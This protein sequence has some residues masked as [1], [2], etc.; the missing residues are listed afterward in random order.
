[1][2]RP[3][4]LVCLGILLAASI[5][6]ALSGDIYTL[7]ALRLVQGLGGCATMVIVYAIAGFVLLTL[8]L[9]HRGQV[10]AAASTA[11]VA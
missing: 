8:C 6:C 7:L 9:P 5:G 11:T 1:M 4:L 10:T 2:V 3:T